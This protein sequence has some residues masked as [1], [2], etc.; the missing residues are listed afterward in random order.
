MVCEECHGGFLHDDTFT[1]CHFG[2]SGS[3]D[4]YQVIVLTKPY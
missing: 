3:E 1:C 4:G 2:V